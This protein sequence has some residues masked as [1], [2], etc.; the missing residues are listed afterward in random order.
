MP[1]FMVQVLRLALPIP[2]GRAKVRDIAGVAGKGQTWL[3]TG[4]T[5]NEVLATVALVLCRTGR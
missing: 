1:G 3:G 5:A 4:R 2:T